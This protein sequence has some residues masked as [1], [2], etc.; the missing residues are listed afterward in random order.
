MTIDYFPSSGMMFIHR[1]RKLFS[2][3][4]VSLCLGLLLIFFSAA[5]MSHNTKVSRDGLIYFF[6]DPLNQDIFKAD[7]QGVKADN[8]QVPILVTDS[9]EK[10]KIL[11]LSQSEIP[12]LA[13]LRQS[14]AYGKLIDN[15]SIGDNKPIGD[16]KIISEIASTMNNDQNFIIPPQDNVLSNQSNPD[17]TR[18]KSLQNFTKNLDN[19]QGL[20]LQSRTSLPVK[21]QSNKNQIAILPRNYP[22]IPSHERE[23][24]D[25][26][27]WLKNALPIIPHKVKSQI[28]IIIDDVGLDQKR[29]REVM[30]LPSFVTVSLMSYAH[31][32]Q[33]WADL[34]RSK[35][36]ELMMHVPMQPVYQNI[37]P[38]PDA[39]RNDLSPE[40]IRQRLE[41]NLS[42]FTGY[43]GINNHMGSQFTQNSRGMSIVMDVL[44]EKGLAFIDSV[45]IGNS[46]G[47]SVASHFN[48][49]TAARDIFI[50]NELNRSSINS[51]LSQL[52]T[53]A[54]RHGTA[55]AIGHPHDVTIEALKAWL[56]TL[57]AKG[58][59]LVPVS[60]I[61]VAREKKSEDQRLISQGQ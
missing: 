55:I 53:L 28:A 46:V 51:L 52:E 47:Y 4:M 61:I 14:P 57:E 49:P 15:K 38:G 33:D 12:E 25:N 19:Q 43:I 50:D 40:E 1:H 39:L 5:S 3:A 44:H 8:S 48:V 41:V 21:N 18:S 42:H 56:P 6:S 2:S 22:S 36:H 20:S 30:D 32:A 45:T 34:A 24:N 9:E 26:P 16:E 29:A 27:L 13:N 54:Q 17:D 60:S 59:E 37:N 10:N 23:N 35:G 7:S 58:I 31:N 11:S